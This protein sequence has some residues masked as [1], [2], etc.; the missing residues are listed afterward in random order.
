MKSELPQS[1]A[2]CA[3]LNSWRAGLVTTSD[4]ANAAE[5]ITGF[6]TISHEAVN[7][8]WRTFLDTVSQD[9]S[10]ALPALPLPGQPH[11]V[12]TTLLQQAAHPEGFVGFG[13]RGVIEFLPSSAARFH[14]I[15][16]AIPV[17]D[18]QHARQT[19]L[20]QLSESTEQLNSMS[21]MGNRDSA[22]NATATAAFLHLPPSPSGRD[23]ETAHLAFKIARVCAFAIN[24]SQVVNS[25]SR[26]IARISVL[27]ELERSA[28]DLLRAVAIHYP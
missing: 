14:D 13:T 22:D 17:L 24:H 9:R 28:N 16:H 7:I 26:D 3:W 12:P 21:V 19:F 4:C 23:I 27:R 15:D 1:I 5:S 18:R 6:H 25:R 20:M 2:L 11:G 8:S 10:L